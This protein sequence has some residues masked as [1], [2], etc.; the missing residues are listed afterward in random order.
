MSSVVQDVADIPNAESYSLRCLSAFAICCITSLYKG[1][2][3][4]PMDERFVTDEMLALLAAQSE[5]IE[6]KDGEIVNTCR[7][8]ESSDLHLLAKNKKQWAVAP[9][10]NHVRISPNADGRTGSECLLWLERQ[11]P[12]SVLYVSFGSTTSMTGEQIEALAAGLKGSKQRFLWVLR[13]A[14]KGDIFT[15]EVRNL[16]LP[17]G[18]EESVEE[19]GLVVRDWV[20]QT[21]ILAHPAVGAFMSHCGW[22][23]CMESLSRGVPIAAWPIHSDQPYNALLITKNLKVGIEVRDWADQS[24]VVSSSTIK[25][26]VEKLMASEEGEQIRR[27]A[28]ELGSVLRQAVEEGGVS[29]VEMDSFIAHIT[30]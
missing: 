30:R 14:D 15:G 9:F 20:P 22:N 17:N 5:F 23:S 25:K 21:E 10:L 27:R 16:E 7:Q 8:I 26:A 24:K 18:F 11:P 13:D 19:S 6:I 28:E 29:R 3:I 12:K 4:P 2:E 1:E